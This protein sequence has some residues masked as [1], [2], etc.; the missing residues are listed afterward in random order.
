MID[1]A[2][3]ALWLM[4][5][6]V[7]SGAGIRVLWLL[8]SVCARQTGYCPRIAFR[9]RE[10]SLAAMSWQDFEQE[11]A[12]TVSRCIN[13]GVV[14]LVGRPG[15]GGVDIEVRNHAGRLVL[16]VQCKHRRNPGHDVE[17]SAIQALESVKRQMGV[18]AWLMT[19]GRFSPHSRDLA[20]RLG[21]TL[22]D[23]ATMDRLR[24]Q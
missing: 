18:D 5:L 17:P 16:I 10:H 8:R 21:V 3:L 24:H 15:D 7:A 12:R 14:R 19:N 4:E 13:N 2:A 23:G 9:P 22:I 1:H 11:C 6:S 20:A